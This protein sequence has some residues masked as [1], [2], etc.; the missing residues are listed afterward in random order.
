[1]DS[2]DVETVIEYGNLEISGNIFVN[3][4]NVIVKADS[5]R[6]TGM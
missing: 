4:S 6:L 2:I 1:M 5:N 3:L